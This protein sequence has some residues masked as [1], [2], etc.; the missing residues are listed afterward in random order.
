MSTL[1]RAVSAWLKRPAK[2]EA[3]TIIDIFNTCPF[4]KGRE[5]K[6]TFYDWAK[7]SI[8]SPHLE[9]SLEFVAG[10]VCHSQVLLSSCFIS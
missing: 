4:N 6:G 5:K 8:P 3:E 7:V 2:G 9:S 1:I 10:L